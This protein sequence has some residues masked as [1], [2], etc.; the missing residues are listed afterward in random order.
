ME[1]FKLVG[2][3]VVDDSQAKQSIGNIKGE[4]SGLSGVFQ[5]AGGAVGRFV[6]GIGKIAGAVGVFKVVDG[7][8]N[9][10][11]NSFDGAISRV[12]T[13]NQFPRVL[14]QMGV[15][16]EDA[17][18]SMNALS[19]G[20]QGL[21]TTLDDIAGSTQRMFTILGDIDLATES[22]LALNN[23]FLASGASQEDASRGTEQY[24]QML[25]AGKV[26]MQSW[27]TLQETMP[28][29]LN[30]TAEAFGFTG[31]SAQNDF[32][33][34][35]LAGEITMEEFNAKMIE[36]SEG[37]GGFAEMALEGS[38]GIATSWQNIQTAVTTGVANVIQA[39]DD[40]LASNGFGGIPEVMDRIKDATGQA[41]GAIV[42]WVPIAL[43]WITS[44]YETISESTAWQSMKGAIRDLIE[45]GQ[46]LITGFFQSEA[47]ETIKQTLSDLAVAVGEIDFREVI[48]QVGEFIDKWSPLIIG[49]MG[50]VGAFKI[51]IPIITAFKTAMMFVATV[52]MAITVFGGLAGALTFLIPAFLGISAPVLA[53]VAI[54]GTLIAIGVALWKNWDT[55]SAKAS[56][57]G[58]KIGEAWN[59]IV[60]SIS[61]AWNNINTT[62]S[63]GVSRMWNSITSTL[64]N[65]INSVI[66]WGS[67]MWSNA[68]T[69]GSNFVTS[70]VG[71]IKQLPERMQ[72]WLTNAVTRVA[73]WGGSLASKGRESIRMLITAVVNGAK[74]LPNKMIGI[75]K[76]VV[77][78]FWNGIT[79][80][81]GWIR[82][83]VNGFFEGIVDG[84]KSF[85][86]IASPSKLFRD[87]V[88]K[89]IPAGIA[90]GIEENADLPF[91][92]L[93]KVIG[94]EGYDMR[95]TVKKADESGNAGVRGGRGDITQNVTIVSPKSTA[96]D[97]ARRMKRQSQ[98]LALEF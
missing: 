81:G 71:F 73:E 49:I 4:A 97:I 26:D 55:V 22:T 62:V 6:G 11:T 48:S 61:N 82:E 47:W 69:I 20:I 85:L 50:A 9:M 60:A 51:I 39:F 24:L 53:V 13:L 98:S 21:P 28:Y 15:A 45:V 5:K 38:R 79:S 44:L 2:S 64:S 18:A 52:K 16:G 74:A 8:I 14:E 42:E 29:A 76:D 59:S 54:I 32:Y 34:A 87:E 84:A 65:I 12:D 77:R 67:N 78:G 46:E 40:W 75:G 33:D 17:E 96:T 68:K 86:K 70:I 66:S 35:L 19:E 41:F 3:I 56:E 7:A 27:R 23:A 31:Q 58:S 63:E 83:K 89:W 93:N 92:A 95:N 91:D 94:V 25:S 30:E 37:T 43:D 90:V 80:L 88:G 36:L 72:T 57:L 1:I 10:I